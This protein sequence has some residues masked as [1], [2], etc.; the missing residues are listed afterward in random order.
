MIAET[1]TSARHRFWRLFWHGF[2]E[3][4]PMCARCG[5]YEYG[6]MHPNGMAGRRIGRWYL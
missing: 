4:H 3:G 2:R 6:P 1:L 5:D